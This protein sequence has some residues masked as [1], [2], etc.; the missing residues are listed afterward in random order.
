[1]TRLLLSVFFLEI[2]L[3]L[4]VVPWSTYWERNYFS[5]LIP[6]IHIVISNFFFR[7]AVSGLGVLN[8]VAAVTE[9]ASVFASRRLSSG[10]ISVSPAVEE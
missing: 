7:G 3:V 10:V 6:F 4:I 8:L 5:D 9:V 2:G 1:M